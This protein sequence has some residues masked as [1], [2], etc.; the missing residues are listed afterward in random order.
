MSK[1]PYG[2]PLPN[3]LGTDPPLSADAP[4]IGY[5]LNH[6]CLR[7][8]DL[9]KSLH[10]YI[11]LMG[12]RT[13]YASN[14]GPFTVYF[15]GYPQND[16]HRENLKEFGEQT[17]IPDTLGLLELLHMHGA[18]NQPEG[19]YGSGN[20]APYLGFCHLGFGVPDLPAAMKRL[21]DNGVKVIRDI[22]IPAEE[23][24]IRHVPITEWENGHGVGI[25]TKGTETEL[26]PIFKQIFT[27]FAFVQD[28][29]SA[30]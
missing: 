12:M 20:Q 27:N 9:D 17:S 22:G 19:F 6:L 26:H 3:G 4:T 21:K 7:V 8:R 2:V 28:P 5:K 23:V 18:E 10:F 16:R 25:E 29:V 14:N 11:N 13:V 24:S 15:L 30:S 1:F